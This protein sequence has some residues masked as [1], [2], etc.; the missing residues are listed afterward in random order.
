MTERSV[1][2]ATFC[3]ERSYQASPQRV[4]HAFADPEA[5]ARWFAGPEEWVAA[6]AEVDF[7]VGGRET[8]V[9]GSKGGPVSRFDAI[10]QDIVPN[11]RIMFSYDMHLDDRRISVSLTTIEFK[12]E[13]SGTRLVFTE[14]GA[15]LD[16]WDNPADREEGTAG[17]LDALGA[18][19]ERQK[20][21]A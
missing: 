18:E 1:T 20:S 21:H 7:R 12:P 15:Y 6:V 5:K 16:G 2:H 9:R 14:Q 10:Y 8:N 13:G 3:L 4:F 11:E 17:W 19:L